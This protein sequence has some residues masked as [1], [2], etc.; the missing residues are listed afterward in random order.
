MEEK[1]GI[2]TG[3]EKEWGPTFDKLLEYH[4]MPNDSLK[5]TIKFIFTRKENC[6]QLRKENEVLV[7]EMKKWMKP[8]LTFKKYLCER[9][10]KKEFENYKTEVD[11]LF[12]ANNF[13]EKLSISKEKLFNGIIQELRK[14][15]KQVSSVCFMC[16]QG[17]I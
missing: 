6:E 2:R 7:S 12:E 10:Y 13:D 4:N 5:D 9:E 11:A 15:K 14:G 1:W 16:T 8:P 3:V 17:P